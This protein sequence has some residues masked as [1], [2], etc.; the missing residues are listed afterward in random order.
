MSYAARGLGQTLGQ[1]I[2]RLENQKYAVQCDRWAQI[3]G[4]PGL[5]SGMRQAMLEAKKVLRT[6]R[7]DT[8][9][10]YAMPVKG[11]M[12]E[13][14]EV[15]AL[16]LLPSGRLDVRFNYGLEGLGQAK[17]V[18]GQIS[19]QT[20]PEGRFGFPS[21]DPLVRAGLPIAPYIEHGSWET[22]QP[23][24]MRYGLDPYR[25]IMGLGQT[26]YSRGV[27][28]HRP[29]GLGQTYY[30][31]GRR[32]QRRSGAALGQLLTSTVCDPTS[33][34]RAFQDRLTGALNAGSQAALVGGAAAGVVGA[35]AG[36]HSAVI[37]A[38]LGA[39]VGWTANLVW[40]AT[41]RA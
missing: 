9:R 38:V 13:G 5:V 16:R 28:G 24:I 39:L 35:V 18:P 19:F 27:R 30:T 29:A 1:A 10:I 3:A 15:V 4:R 21:L 33:V 2:R 34:S 31:R 25:G 17:I 32:D 14:D 40:T 36:K 22:G 7:D 11:W 6:N 20:L 8:C 23:D 26:Y 12:R 37:G 41:H